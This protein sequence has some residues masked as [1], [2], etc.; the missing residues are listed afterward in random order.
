MSGPRGL[1][2]IRLESG[3]S[4]FTGEGFV[5]VTALDAAG[6]ML[7]TGQLTPAECREHGTAAFEAAGAAVFDAALWAILTDRIGLD[8]EAAA[9]V[10][11]D[12]RQRRAE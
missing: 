6:E 1:G 3:V 10:L 12:L 7:A 5:A 8:Q 2:E 9:A 11:V 4:A